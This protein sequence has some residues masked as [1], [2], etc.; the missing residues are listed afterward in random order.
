MRY[1]K[2]YI[3]ILSSILCSIFMFTV[4]FSSWLAVSIPSVS[5]SG[6]FTA[7]GVETKECITVAPPSMFSYSSLSFLDTDGNEADSGTISVVYTLWL[8]N[9]ADLISSEAK[10]SDIGS[11][12]VYF[13][14]SYENAVGE[15]ES[16]FST[17]S[18]DTNN[19]DSL[20]RS[21]SV[22]VDGETVQSVA[23]EGTSLSFSHTFTDFSGA[24]TDSNSGAAYLLVTVD[25]I[26]NVPKNSQKT[27]TDAQGATQYY[28]SN[29]RNAFGKYLSVKEEGKTQFNTSAQVGDVKEVSK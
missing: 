5:T 13:N 17:L 9:C 6:E 24:I 10:I 28:P 16:L 4:G 12:E 21:V 19:A 3:P 2:K 23:N 14:L 22:K 8:D 15:Y 7:Y 18:F 1:F 11:I 29:F 27:Y 25:Y 20:S 26:F